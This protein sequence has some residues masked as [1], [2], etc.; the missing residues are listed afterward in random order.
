MTDINTDL[1]YKI[2]NIIVKLNKIESYIDKENDITKKYYYLEQ[3]LKTLKKKIPNKKTLGKSLN[4]KDLENI[5]EDIVEGLGEIDNSF[6]G[7]IASV[8]D[9]L[10]DNISKEKQPELIKFLVALIPVY[11]R[12]NKLVS[13]YH[14]LTYKAVDAAI[15]IDPTTAAA[16]KTASRVH[17]PEYKDLIPMFILSIVTFY[18]VG[19]YKNFFNT[20]L[21]KFPV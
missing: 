21:N 20:L 19:E 8:S 5:I 1:T 10:N 18:S 12:W 14:E 17:K 4:N 3:K 2:N 11:F 6:E 16:A 7:G 15:V 13:D 9:A